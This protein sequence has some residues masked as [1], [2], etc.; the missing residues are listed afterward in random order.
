MNLYFKN[1]NMLWHIVLNQ[2][3][4]I[5]NICKLSPNHKIKIWLQKKLILPK[6]AEQNIYK[7]WNYKTVKKISFA[8]KTTKNERWFFM[9]WKSKFK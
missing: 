8:N 5:T 4:K 3:H 6:C 9:I 2:M 1:V 7:H